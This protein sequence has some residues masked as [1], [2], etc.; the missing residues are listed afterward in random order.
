MNLKVKRNASF[1]AV[2]SQWPGGRDVNLKVKR[3]AS[4][5]TVTSS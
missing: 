2:T 5:C 3:N 4:F 1:F